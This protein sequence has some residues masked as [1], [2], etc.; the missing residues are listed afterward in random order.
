MRVAG[1]LR[2]VI[3]TVSMDA[4]AVELD[5]ELPVGTPVT[6]LGH[7]VQAEA[8]A[9]AAGT[10]GYEIVTGIRSSPDRTRRFVVDAL[11]PPGGIVREHGDRLHR[12]RHE[13]RPLQ[14]GRRG[15]G[16]RAFRVSNS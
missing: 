4:F 7:G 10:I 16:R 13:L 12:Q 8:H 6:L 9:R 11:I 2:R 1:E 3:G 14:G 15:R 5:R